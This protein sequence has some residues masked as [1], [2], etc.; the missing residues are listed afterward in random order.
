M[1]RTSAGRPLLVALDLPLRTGDAAYTFGAGA[2]AGAHRGI[3]VVVPFGHRL[4]PGIVLGEGAPRSDLKRVLAVTS[5]VPLVPAPVVD[6]AEWLAAEYLS[7]VGEALAAVVPWDA[8]WAGLRLHVAGPI[9]PGLPPAA[10]TILESIHRRPATLTAAWRVL[11]ETDALEAVAASGALT[12]VP[13]F[14]GA[15]VVASDLPA[16]P[17][18]V[19]DRAV[20]GQSR[21]SVRAASV[22]LEGAIAESLAGGPRAL[23]VAGWDRTPAY[24]AAVRRAL[25][26]G[27]SCVA[28]FPSVGAATAFG[29]AARA[30]GLAPVVL[31]GEQTP[32]QRLAAWRV[33]TDASRTLVVGTRAAIFAPVRDPVV[34]VVDDEDSSGHKEERAP[35]Y[36]TAV[37][38]AERTRTQGVLVIGATTPTVATYAGVADGRLRLVALPSPRPRIGV[39]DLRRRSDPA[40]P[41]SRPVADALR[42]VVRRRG[43]VIVLAD[44]KGYAGG[45]HCLECGAVERCPRCA[46]TMRYERTGR[47]LR[48]GICG[49]TAPA[50]AVCSSCGA[51]R[52]APLGAGTERLTATLR[53]LTPAV[54]R[55]DSDVAPAGDPAT[56]LRPFRERG[57]VLVATHVV[58]PYIEEL[59]PDLVVLIAAD[60]MLHRPEFRAA[61]RAL[62]L[63]RTIGMASRATVLVETSDPAHAAIRAALAPSLKPFYADELAQRHSLGYPPAR[64]LIVVTVIARSAALVEVMG[65]RLAAGSSAALE[66]LGPMPRQGTPGVRHEFVIKTI[67]R[68]AAR[69]LVMPLL[70]G[71]DR[72]VEVTVD[73]DP[74]EL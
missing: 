72:G 55:F 67:D 62:A 74:H 48:C 36:V 31:H 57:G 66:V 15:A 44:R 13:A 70:T 40:A 54:W 32:A 12:A 47:R 3:G 46:V 61:E 29:A 24:L 16:P 50:P 52:L 65:A 9:P 63:L 51:P 39:V 7:S 64:S 14:A 6:R 1:T 28:A 35:R 45:L 43:R 37:A 42:R 71:A 21:E 56:I 20:P 11:A 17:T 5:G 4:M 49:L 38:A 22:R 68:T 33:V 19:E 41:V 73:V 34:A 30:A 53:R 60:R 2:F 69:A 27:W 25:A 58:L 59:R 18:R 23:L 8:L 26:T 10:A